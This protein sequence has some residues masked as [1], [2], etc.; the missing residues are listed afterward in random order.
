MSRTYQAAP[1][2]PA[3]PPQPE[4]TIQI[5]AATLRTMSWAWRIN[6]ENTGANPCV[7]T[8]KI[9]FPFVI[10]GFHIGCD[11]NVA[12]PDSPFEVQ[13]F[14]TDD[15]YTRIAD[16]NP[17]RRLLPT[18]ANE[19]QDA[20]RG[21]FGM[22]HT[23]SSVNPPNS[24]A[25]AVIGQTEFSSGRRLTIALKGVGANQPEYEI[26]NGVLTVQQIG[27]ATPR[28][29]DPKIRARAEVEADPGE[30]KIAPKAPPKAKAPAAPK[31][32]QP[33]TPAPDDVEEPTT[34][35]R[36]LFGIRYPTT[37]GGTA[38]LTGAPAT[39]K[40]APIYDT[41]ALRAMAT[42]LEYQFGSR[43]QN[44]PAADYRAIA[45]ALASGGPYAPNLRPTLQ[46]VIIAAYPGTTAANV[47]A[48]LARVMG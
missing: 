31:A 13:L 28:I 43:G 7:T 18:I 24:I 33:S 47:Q 19:E 32:P 12:A 16:D 45:N 46:Q 11:P 15:D 30:D 23:P 1:T 27:G 48:I 21:K 41:N 37:T 38:T 35:P 36:A 42:N 8:P 20:T 10:T 29:R 2:K 22:L 17:S 25:T 3:A 4:P 40:G 6:A 9:P 14:V 39:P 44:I 26:A 5:G 34:A